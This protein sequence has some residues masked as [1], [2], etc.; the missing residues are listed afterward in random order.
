MADF[1]FAIS[2]NPPPSTVDMSDPTEKATW[3][4]NPARFNMG[5][6]LIDASTATLDTVKDM[7]DRLLRGLEHLKTAPDPKK[8]PDD[9]QKLVSFQNR[10]WIYCLLQNSWTSNMKTIMQKYHEVHGND[11]VILYYCFLR[12]FAG[13]NAENI[14]EAYSQLSES[15]VKLSLYNGDVSKFTNAIRAPIHRLIKAKENP[16]VH[17]FLYIFHGC[18]DAPNE[19]FRHFIFQKEACFRRGGPTRS[20]S[21]LDLLDELDTEYTR[22]KNLGRWEKQEDPYVLALQSSF[23]ALQANYSTLQKDYLSLKSQLTKKTPTNN[24]Q[25]PAKWKQGEPEVVELNG[26]IW[27]WCAKCFN[28]AWTSSCNQ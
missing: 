20:L 19:E 3:E 8:N 9:A 10:Q 7:H 5:N 28:G 23:S 26:V 14:V 21:L 27:K 16:S 25:K 13:T 18:L 17:H 15:K 24:V 22:I 11:G 6:L 1:N 12:H 2:E 4:S